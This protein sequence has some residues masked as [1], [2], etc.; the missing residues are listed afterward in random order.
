MTDGLGYRR[1]C[2]T[3]LVAYITDLPEQQLIACISKNASPMTTAT[4]PQ[5][6]DSVPHP[7]CTGVST[8]TQIEDLCHQ[9]HPWDIISFQKKVKEV[10]LLGV[11]LPFWQDWKFMDPAIFLVGEI[12][13][14][15]HKF[16]FD[17]VLKWCKEVVGNHLIDTRYKTQHKHVGIRHFTSGA[18]H[19]KQ[20][21]GREHRDIQQTLVPMIAKAT[22]HTTLTFVY[23]IRSMIKF[24]YMAQNQTYSDALIAAMVEALQEF[25]AMQHA[26]VEAEG[27]WGRVV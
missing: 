7:R 17:H 21:T 22:A 1:Y 16:F 24:I 9:V 10:K 20:M 23:C 26:I 8:L 15:C 25:H 4:L 13:H 3:P 6:G 2:F 12:L 14:M 5:F 18:S 27:Q 19:I 11:H